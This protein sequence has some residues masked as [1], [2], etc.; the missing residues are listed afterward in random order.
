M[1]LK[2][3]AGVVIA[4]MLLTTFLTGCSTNGTEQSDGGNGT[5][6]G[7]KTEAAAMGRYLEE[8][9]KLPEGIDNIQA[10]CEMEDDSLRLAGSGEK[11][12]G[13]WDTRDQGKTWNKV[14]DY[15]EELKGS[16]TK[17]VSSVALS[18][19]GGAAA[20]IM[21]YSNINQQSG[22]GQVQTEY[23]TLDDTGKAVQLPVQ[24][25]G[26]NTEA[27][28]ESKSDAQSEGETT[29]QQGGQGVSLHDL[30]YLNTWKYTPDNQLA[31]IGVDGKIYI[32][33]SA[34]GALIKSI[35]NSE[36]YFSN[37]GF[38]GN[39]LVAYASNGVYY[40]DMATGNSME[41]DAV[42][43]EQLTDENAA[44][45]IF[46][47]GGGSD[48]LLQG[49]K[50]DNILYFCNK[51]GIFRHV[52]NGNVSE[53]LVDGSLN[54]MSDPSVM[55]SDVAAMKDG[56]F[57]LAFTKN[58]GNNLVRY[59]YSEDTPS[60]P[61]KE[62]N[63]YSLKENV[64]IRQAIAL[65]QKQNPDIR[66]NYEVGI[67]GDD[68]VTVSDA[69]RTLNTNIMAGKGPDLF[70][71]DGMSIKSY[72]DKGLLE[73]MSA[74]LKQ[75]ADQ[76]GLLENITKS[77]E[78]DGKTYA[79]PTRFMIPGVQ[80][81]K[82]TLDGIT[83][84]KTL[85]DTVESMKQENGDKEILGSR[86]PNDLLDRLYDTSAQNWIKED[87]TLKED[88]LKEFF[89][90]LKRIY[91][92]DKRD[93]EENNVNSA[94]MVFGGLGRIGACISDDSMRYL[95]GNA[96]LNIG[97]INSIN[98]LMQVLAVDA[99]IKDSTYKPLDGQA[100]K[101]FVP[102][103]M[104]GISSKAVN[105]ESAEKLAA[106]MMSKDAQTVSQGG[107]FPVNK[108]AFEELFNND[109]KSEVPM[110]SISTVSESGVDLSIDLKWPTEEQAK[111]FKSFIEGLTTPSNTDSMIREAVSGAAADCLNGIT[112][113]DE[114]VKAVMQKVNLYLSE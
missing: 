85:A 89:T 111:Q 43:N 97:N 70:V 84:L 96:K 33:D 13:V 63:I 6:K 35:D 12:G 74:I 11:G 64:E 59:T 45:G 17:Y 92:V 110:M 14:F 52:L 25:G 26:N 38:V 55:F 36:A 61:E 46:F 32:I 54:S 77:F 103:T 24:L 80:S 4:A 93:V 41:K 81:D 75:V 104:I 90:Q 28:S 94:T 51:E 102:S 60:V 16:D 23:W 82:K 105:K 22:Q 3:M 7:N 42:L 107:G 58:N 47:G 91:D 56:T 100:S 83:D 87:G 106:F 31:G 98:D 71:L 10:L 95:G 5:D 19:K 79:I 39:T 27:K 1:I 108:A 76:D 49:G 2:R 65:F 73:D 8:D 62:V 68:G 29:N 53:Q 88:A 113:V 69:I 67:T 30:Q 9:I 86:Q 101:I 112:S 34:S 66:V 44:G 114:A 40:Y 99:K 50:E 78:K 20:I 48:V 109:S 72:E 15:P 57:F 18:P 21:D 37:I